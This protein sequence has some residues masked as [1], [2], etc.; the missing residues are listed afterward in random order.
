M[1]ELIKNMSKKNSFWSYYGKILI[2]GVSIWMMLFSTS[3]NIYAQEPEEESFHR[4]KNYFEKQKYEEALI[5]FDAAIRINSKYA[6]AYFYRGVVYADRYK[7]DEALLD[8][9]KAIEIDPNLSY[10]YANRAMVYFLMKKYDK[11]WEDT[12]KAVSLGYKVD[13]KFLVSLK[14][15]SNREN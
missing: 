9:T 7:F 4:G 13:E 15:A 10:V 11:S 12:H 1:R 3:G 8:Y 2:V 5:A 14:K 6:D